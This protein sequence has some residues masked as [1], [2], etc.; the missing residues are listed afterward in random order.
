[1]KKLLD[2]S[3][4]LA[5]QQLQEYIITLTDVIKNSLFVKEQIPAEVILQKNPAVCGKDSCPP[6]E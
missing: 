5:F 1:L 2:T 3:K 4:K 6:A